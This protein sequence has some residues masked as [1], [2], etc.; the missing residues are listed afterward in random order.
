[1]EKSTYLE[2]ALE[3]YK[4]RHIEDLVKKYKTRRDEIKED[5]KEKFNSKA[6]NPFNSGSFAKHTAINTK[7]DL[8]L[9]VPFKRDSFSTIKEMFDEVYD[10]LKEKYQ[11]SG[12]A[13]VR[14]QKVSIGVIFYSDAEGDR[15]DIDVVPGRELN[16]DDYLT[17]KDLHIY[18]N[19]D[20]W[21]Y[22]KG[23]YQ[24]TNIQ[25]QINHIKGKSEAREVIRLL[26]I[27]KSTNGED[28]KSFLFELF[29]I[30]A[31]DKTEITGDLWDRLK[32]VMTYIKENVVKDG[33]NLIDPGNS[34][35][36][37]MDSLDEWQKEQL[38]DKMKNMIER[39]ED[40]S[41]NLKTYFPKN[42]KFG[43]DKN[44]SS[45]DNSYRL[46]GGTAGISIPKKGQR[47][48]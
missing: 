13:E 30:K 42:K 27:W 36:N 25:S 38:S 4:M 37:L 24:K 47:F 23:S 9:V 41:E 46:K 20:L 2:D 35:N 5:L 34:N 26:K 3:T 31:F 48:G 39:I 7:F 17:S 14:K 19:E 32:V 29:T 1:M 15:I 21:G 43:E 18:F 10:F 22:E 44:N 33:F 16:D 28:Y 11:D 45:E 12:K 6:Y 8:D 40:N